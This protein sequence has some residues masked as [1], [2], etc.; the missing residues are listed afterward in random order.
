MTRL[1][2]ATGDGLTILTERGDGW[3]A[4][5]RLDGLPTQCVAAD[6]GRPQLVYCGTFGQGLWRSGDG[7]DTWAHVGEGIATAEVMAVAVSAGERAGGRGVVWAG[8]EP[9]A[10]FRSE[11][12]GDTW[13]GRPAL[14]DIPSAPT[15]SFPPRPWTHHVR[16]IAPDPSA[17]GRLFVGSCC[18][19]ARSGTTCANSCGAQHSGTYGVGA[20]ADAVTTSLQMVAGHMCLLGGLRRGRLSCVFGCCISSSGRSRDQAAHGHDEYRLGGGLYR[21]GVRVSELLRLAHNR[22]RRDLAPGVHGG[23]CQPRHIL[24][25]RVGRCM[26]T[27]YGRCSSVRGPRF[28]NRCRPDVVKRAG[29]RVQRWLHRDRLHQRRAGLDRLL[30]QPGGPGAAHERWGKN[31]ALRG[32]I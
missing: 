16:W 8:T 2:L 12:G 15:W 22:C 20:W 31:L 32:S 28:Y 30:Q 6:P 10:L 11:D 29:S 18:Y 27:A 4:E 26:G 14:Q 17:S 19:D 21:V 24:F 23:P 25:P 3:R 7:G 5:V 13:E 9:S 1:Y